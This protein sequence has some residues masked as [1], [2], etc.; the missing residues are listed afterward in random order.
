MTKI[1]LN[2]Q[3]IDTVVVPYI[4]GMTDSLDKVL[5]NISKIKIPSRVSA[6]VADLTESV[7]DIKRDVKNFET[8]LNDVK[9]EYT[10]SIEEISENIKEMDS[11]VISARTMLIA[12]K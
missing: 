10:N 3:K 8:W 6:D 2:T 11:S 7:N 12:K 9:T 5:E 4:D 1:L